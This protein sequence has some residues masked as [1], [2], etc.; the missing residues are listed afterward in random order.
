MGGIELLKH[1]F[2]MW[3]YLKII[4]SNGNIVE[5]KNP[6]AKLY[7]P[8]CRYDC[9]Q[10]TIARDNDFIDRKYLDYLK[11][12]YIKPDS[13]ILDIGANI[14]NHSVYYAL[15]CKAKRIYQFE[16]QQDIFKILKKNIELNYLQDICKPYNIGLG[17]KNGNGRILSYDR[18]NSGGTS[19]TMDDGGDM[20]VKRL[21]E[22]CTE[23]V[24]FIKIDV[25]GFEYNVLLG[26]GALL[27]NYSPVIYMEVYDDK[28][29]QV[30][31]LLDSYG[32]RKIEK[33][34]DADY[35]YKKIS[36]K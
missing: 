32:Y 20:K 6:D 25:E 13:V 12:K 2:S 15:A 10:M 35:I 11:D 36:W 26:A 24:D 9:L 18:D 16:P 19:I 3:D 8:Y 4:E 30:N 17:S 1:P 34:T 29:E 23:K 28:F 5:T 14:G 7:I 31:K 27:K 33:V 21:D 22:I